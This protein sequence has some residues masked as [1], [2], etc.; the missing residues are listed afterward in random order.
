MTF[1]GSVT[2]GTTRCGRV[3]YCCSSTT[4]GSI[5]TKRSWS[6][7]KSIEQRGNDGIDANGFA[8]AG[9]A[10][11][12]QVRHF[13][14]VRDDRMAV[15]VLA[16]RQRNAGFGIAPFFGFEE[17]AHDDFGLDRVRDFDTDRAFAGHGREDIDALGFERGGDVVVQRRRFFPASR[18]APGAVRSG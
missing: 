15:N 12:E 10:G 11:D 6:G 4:F 16:Q 17:V 2:T 13:R 8:G 14:K 3:L 5:I 18:P 1:F 7:R 9:A